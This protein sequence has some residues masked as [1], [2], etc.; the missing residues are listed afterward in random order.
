MNL[1]LAFVLMVISLILALGFVRGRLLC[2]GFLC[3]G[4][5]ELPD[6]QVFGPLGR[7]AT[8]AAREHDPLPVTF[9]ARRPTFF[10]LRRGNLDRHQSLAARAESTASTRQLAS[11]HFVLPP[12]SPLLPNMA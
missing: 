4:L 10:I 11:R 5:R 6:A 3:A 1:Y 2:H 8:L 9:H 7:I 12:S